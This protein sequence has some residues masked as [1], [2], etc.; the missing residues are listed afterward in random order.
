MKS[1]FCV[2]VLMISAATWL[3][4]AARTAAADWS[5]QQVSKLPKSEQPIRLFNG[6]DL[7][8]WK[9]QIAKYF[10]VDDGAI[11]ARNGKENAPA[12]STY[13]VTTKKYR[14]FEADLRR[15]ARH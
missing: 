9:G 1:R 11:V 4:S 3:V 7:S 15:Q 13:L 5:E 12:A 10:S 8:G 6:T 2:A 14:N